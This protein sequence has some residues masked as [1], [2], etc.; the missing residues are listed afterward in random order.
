MIVVN[1]L[2]AYVIKLL[3]TL[4]H[5]HIHPLATPPTKKRK[6]Q[7]RSRAERTVEKAM[8]SFMAYQREA[9][10]RYQRNEEERWQREIE[11]E[12]KRRKEDQEH[13]MRMMRMMGQ[14]FQGSSYHRQYEFDYL[15]S[16]HD[17]YD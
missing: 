11:M 5:S 12:E 2:C 17:N 9:E 7:K 4:S 13:E 8:E 14:M 6:V 3:C 16:Q 1:V 10:E 15:P